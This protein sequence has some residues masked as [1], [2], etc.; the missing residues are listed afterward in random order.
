MSDLAEQP[1]RLDC[2]DVSNLHNILSRFE[3]AI[4]LD[5]PSYSFQTK[6]AKM[7]AVL[8]IAKVMGCDFANDSARHNVIYEFPEL[9]QGDHGAGAKPTDKV[10]A[11]LRAQR[12]ASDVSEPVNSQCAVNTQSRG[13]E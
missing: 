5:C 11:N 6:A 12:K 1:R 3:H 2:D 9:Y 10:G 13:E 8:E 7:A 4:R